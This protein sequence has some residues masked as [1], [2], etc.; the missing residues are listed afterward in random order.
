MPS[1]DSQDLISTGRRAGA[2]VTQPETERASVLTGD[3]RGFEA[4][5]PDSSASEDARP[6]EGRPA[7]PKGYEPPAVIWSE[8]IDQ[9]VML[10][11]A[12]GKTLGWPDAQCSP[13][14]GS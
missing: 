9:A 10:A 13:A 8:P 6:L 12:C 5:D 14:P 1:H 2:E 3:A 11:A 4:A 7:R